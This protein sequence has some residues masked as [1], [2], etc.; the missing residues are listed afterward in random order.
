LSGTPKSSSLRILIFLGALVAAGMLI[1]SRFA[2]SVTPSTDHRVF[3]LKYGPSTSEIAR[4]A[5]VLFEVRSEY[6]DGGAP[7]RAIKRISCAGGEELSVSGDRYYC[8]GKEVAVAKTHSLAGEKLPR[9]FHN[10]KI[11]EDGIFVTGQHRDSFDSRYFGFVKKE[12]VK[13]LAYPLF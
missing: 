5:Y 2:V 7:H 6:I 10:G 1:P 9:F 3:F 4:G 8:G 12:E 11:P 13:A